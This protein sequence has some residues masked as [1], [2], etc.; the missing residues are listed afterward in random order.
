MSASDATGRPLPVRLSLR[1]GA[2]VLG[3]DAA[4]ARYP[5]TVDP[6]IQQGEKLTAPKSEETAA[7]AFGISVALSADGRTALVGA[8]GF[9]TAGMEVGAAW[10][11]TRT[12]ST[13]TQQGARLN[14][15]DET[16]AGQFG[17]SVALSADGNTAVIGGPGDGTHGA[18]WIFTRSGSAWSQQGS[19]LTGSGA[20]GETHIGF[21]VAVSADGATALAGGPG[22][23]SETGAAWVFTRS[24]PTWSQQ[25]EKLTGA[26]EES[27]FAQF[28]LS[29]SLSG[30]GSAALIGGPADSG[31]AGAAWAFT[32]SAS[33]W[34]QQGKKLTG[35][36]ESG[37]GQFGLSVA[38]S[39][40]GS[41]AMIGGP[42]DNVQVGAAWPFARSGSTWSQQG[43]K[44]RGGP[45]EIGEGQFGQSVALSSDGSTALIGAYFENEVVGAAWEFIRH[46]SAWESL[47]G[48]KVGGGE[49]GK[50][51]YGLSVALSADGDSGLVGGEH[52]GTRGAAWALGDP[53]PAAA[54]GA[55]TGV[56][57]STATLTGSGGAGASY[58]A[59]FEYGTSAS[60]GSATAPIAVPNTFPAPGHSA[61]ATPVSAAVGGLLAATTYHYR[62]VIENSAGTSFGADQVLQ[63]AAPPPVAPRL[64]GLR[65]THG[66]WREGTKKASLA[67]GRPPVGTTF[68]FSLDQPASVTLTFTQPAAGRRSGGRCVAPTSRN[69]RA[70][71]CKRT[72][73]RGAL[74]FAAHDGADRISF[75]GSLS[76]SP[77]AP[78]GPLHGARERREQRSSEVA[79]GGALVHDRALGLNAEVAA[80]ERRDVPDRPLLRRVAARRCRSAAARQV[81]PTRAASRGFLR[82]RAPVFPS[83]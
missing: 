59:R 23:E 2:V 44:L 10:V 19:K 14:A 50:A 24:G 26:A 1:A 82:R 48:K 68:L 69:R 30:D 37:A 53:P 47:G 62:L 25:G 77:Q 18:V 79:G 21:G 34:S 83:R 8:N 17:T 28:G 52:D 33:A 13:W 46:A 3:V 36:G 80:H 66:T 16:G 57:Q 5:I 27:G 4:G 54:T 78:A 81:S 7:G 75:Q 74:T 72:V 41:T 29:V 43:A 49:E 42:H 71:S 58:A 56:G 61:A 11:F 73:T 31:D 45:E 70:R 60:Y 63:T 67:A 55:A 76:R 6:L 40:T 9:E 22:D 12:G 20:T 35:G 38:L 32:R 64:S 51:E 15:S 39:A 65:Q